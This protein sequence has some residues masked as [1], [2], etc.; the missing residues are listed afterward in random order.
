MMQRS[1]DFKSLKGRVH[2]RARL[3][4]ES[5]KLILGAALA[6]VI[7]AIGNDPLRMAIICKPASIQTMVSYLLSP[8]CAP[9]EFE[10]YKLTSTLFDMNIELI[11]STILEAAMDPNSESGETKE[12]IIEQIASLYSL[13]PLV[14]GRPM[15]QCSR[16]S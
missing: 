9:N 2:K 7:R 3:I 4:L 10:L 16:R 11:Y 14:I 12:S 13:N 8:D 5:K 6:S 1:N 15:N